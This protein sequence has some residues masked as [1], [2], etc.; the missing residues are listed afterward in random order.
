MDNPYDD[1]DDERE[2]RLRWEKEMHP[3]SLT[4]YRNR[5]KSLHYLL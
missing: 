2:N 3:E 4:L 5:A 1:D